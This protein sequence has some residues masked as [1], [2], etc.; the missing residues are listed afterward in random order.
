[1]SEYEDF[2][3]WKRVQEVEIGDDPE[4]WEPWWECFHAGYKAGFQQAKPFD[5]HAFTLEEV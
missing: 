1:M 3:A 4:D 2:L 5:A